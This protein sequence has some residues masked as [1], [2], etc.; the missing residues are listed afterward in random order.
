MATRIHYRRARSARPALV[1]QN[2][3][4]VLDNRHAGFHRL[5]VVAT[6]QRPERGSR[7][8]VYVLDVHVLLL[9]K[10]I[11]LLVPS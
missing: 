4:A 11:E 1:P 6:S 5:V 7:M 3:S 8:Y 9:E 10:S 2:L